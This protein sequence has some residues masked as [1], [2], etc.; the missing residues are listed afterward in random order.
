MRVEREEAL[1]EEKANDLW[2]SA[3][4][5]IDQ[6]SIATGKYVYCNQSSHAQFP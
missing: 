3:A 4:S 1:G 6:A 2:A 5:V